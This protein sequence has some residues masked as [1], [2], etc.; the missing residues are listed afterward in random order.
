[1]IWASALQPLPDQAAS[2]VVTTP[3]NSGRGSLREAIA[4]A[5]NGDAITFAIGGT[6]T[7]LTGELLISKNLNVLGPGL[8]NLAVSGNNASRVFNIASGAIVNLSGLTICNGH[9]RDGAAGTNSTTPGWPGDD[10]GGIYNSGTLSLTNCVITRC[11]SGQGG[12]GF[13]YQQFIQTPGCSDGGPG[14]NGGGIYN[15]G[16]LTLAACTLSYNT[17]GS[18]GSGGVARLGMYPGG[19]GGSGGRGAG[20]YDV[21]AATFVACTFAFNSAGAGGVGGYGGAGEVSQSFGAVGGQGGVGGNGGA[22][23]SQSS[24]IFISCTF[25][26]NMGGRGGQGGMGGA[27]YTPLLLG[28]VG[29][30][31][32]GGNGAAG[33]SGGGLYCLGFFQSL[34]CTITGN[35]A[36]A[37]GAGGQGGRAG[38]Q[39]GTAVANGGSGGNGGIGGNG[40][41]ASAWGLPALQNV[42]AALNSAAAGGLAGAGGSGSPSGGSGSP[43]SSGLDGSGPDLFG[44]FTSN[45]H[46]LIGLDDGNTGFTDG[47]LGDLVCSGT[48]LNPRVGLLSN[49]GGPTFT[50]ALLS[51]SPALDNGD[52]TIQDVPLG[53]TTDQRGL[54]RRSGSHI[55]IGALE[56]QW[57]SDPIRVAACNRTTNGAVQLAL[58][59]LPGASLTMLAATNPSM[60][61]SAWTV[62]GPIPEIAPGQFQFSDSAPAN[63]PQRIYRVRFP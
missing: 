31:G 59:N 14:G 58:T 34:A 50:C 53:L 1:L 57:A 35:T 32:P 48:P 2:I 63:L 13:S 12:A 23:Y 25:A 19:A 8:T 55:D 40:G 20:I 6:I 45:G 18:G 52:D 44:A 54:P 5:N 27:G 51:G 7:N 22:L 10:G 56:V 33:G 3:A 28:T 15:A 24:P 17:N 46:N 4:I 16:E 42:L 60:P 11:R 47:L 21:G 61:L 43:G 41:G 30:G 39:H 36:G 29:D 9:A 49:N 26:N 38:L 62:L 37:G